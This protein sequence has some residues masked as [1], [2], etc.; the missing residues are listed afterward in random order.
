MVIIVII[1]LVIMVI[2]VIIMV[3]IIVRINCSEEQVV[4]GGFSAM[5]QNPA[6]MQAELSHSHH[7]AILNLMI[8]LRRLLVM[9]VVKK[10]FL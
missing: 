9:M 4:P 1:I 8:T 6:L 5:Q 7:F 10:G 2:R 3:I